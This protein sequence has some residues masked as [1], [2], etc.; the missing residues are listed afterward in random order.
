MI[1]VNKTYINKY[2]SYRSDSSD[3]IESHV[4]IIHEHRSVIEMYTML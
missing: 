2:T 3:Y 1:A 4:Y